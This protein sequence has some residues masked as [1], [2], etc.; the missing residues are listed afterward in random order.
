MSAKTK[1]PPLKPAT[2]ASLVTIV[3]LIHKN[4]ISKSIASVIRSTDQLCDLLGY[5]NNIGRMTKYRI[6][7]E[8]LRHDILRAQSTAKNKKI[9][10]SPTILNLL[11]HHSE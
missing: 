3:F 11:E 9:F 10:L 7:A 6:V 2:Y 5:T 8:L 1:K 4:A